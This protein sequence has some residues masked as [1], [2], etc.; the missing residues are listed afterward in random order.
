MGPRGADPSALGADRAGVAD[1]GDEVEVDEE[2]V[3]PVRVVR[4]EKHFQAA[5]V[6][7]RRWQIAQDAFE[8]GRAVPTVEAPKPAPGN[9]LPR[10]R[11][12][13]PVAAARTPESTSPVVGPASPTAAIEVAP[14][15]VGL[16]IADRVQQALTAPAA[17]AA[18]SALPSGPIFE[19]DTRQTF[20]PALRVI[21]LQLNPAELGA[22]T[23]VLS[24]NDQGLRIELAAE[25]ADTA[26]RVD[27][28]RNV[29]AARLH[30]AG[31]TVTDINVARMAG[32]GMNGDAR[33]Q[34][35]R[36]GGQQEQ[37]LGG[38]GHNGVARDG[39]A[40]QA[41]QHAGRRTGAT[42]ARA[43]GAGL[44]HGAASAPSVTG[45][46]YAGRFRPV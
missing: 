17:S 6:D 34:A 22:V 19:P 9:A 20:A 8:A 35:G 4:Q 39:G 36:H 27:S 45:V 43:E 3:L 46:S 10:D 21:K 28:D 25:R 32:Q 11:L 16:Q 40:H 33:E 38:G 1:V 18:T 14:G 13:A 24:G 37:L 12:A 31:Y 29:L 5:G 41:E 15:A 26:N 23:I 2:M 42:Y 30:G 44:S 7:E